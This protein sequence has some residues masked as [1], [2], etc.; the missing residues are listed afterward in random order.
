MS[1]QVQNTDQTTQQSEAPA[2]VAKYTDKQMNDIVAAR[3]ANAEKKAVAALLKEHG[4]ESIEA[5][6]ELKKIKDAQLTE[7]ERNAATLKEREQAIQAARAEAESARAEVEALKQGVPADK[8][9]RLVKIAG[10]YDGETIA[11]K[12]TAAIKDFPEFVAKQAAAPAANIGKETTHQE[13]SE[14]D[15]LLAMAR[16]QAMLTK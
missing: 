10:T 13:L 3:S 11:D 16:K 8:V 7:A 5:L 4:L 9:A 1:D 14:V 12:L 15:K 2:E 6:A